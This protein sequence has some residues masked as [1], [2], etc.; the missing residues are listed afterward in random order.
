[1]RAQLHS[2][3]CGY[4]IFPA[5]FVEKTLLSPIYWSSHSCSIIGPTDSLLQVF[6]EMWLHHYSLEMYQKMQSP[7]A[8]VCG[9][10][11][12]PSPALALVDLVKLL[13]VLDVS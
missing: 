8:K 5:A 10:L 9:Q 2:F 12:F 4:P 6:V 13:L 1:M 3:A 7:H 11:F